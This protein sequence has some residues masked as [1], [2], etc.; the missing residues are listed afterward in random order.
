VQSLGLVGRGGSPPP[1]EEQLAR[2]AG[3]STPVRALDLSGMAVTPR[4]LRSLS[5]H[6]SHVEWLKVRLAL[7]HTL[8]RALSGI[9][10]GAFSFFFF[11][12]F[13]LFFAFVFALSHP[14]ASPS[15]SRLISHLVS[16]FFFFGQATRA[17]ENKIS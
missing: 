11:F 13:A 16:F 6:L 7:R 15:R 3:G 17:L 14:Q 4:L 5:R 8:H 12:F 1:S 9:V 2:I 10:R